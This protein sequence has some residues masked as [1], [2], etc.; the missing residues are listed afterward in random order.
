[1]PAFT[2]ALRQLTALF[3]DKPMWANVQQRA[4]AQDVSWTASASK[5]VALYEGLRGR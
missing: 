5:Y 2:I 4:M 1:V 3:W